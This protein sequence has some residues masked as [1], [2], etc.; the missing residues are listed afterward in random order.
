MLLMMKKNVAVA[1]GRLE[2]EVETTVPAHP[3]H[4]LLPAAVSAEA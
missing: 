1:E 2:V 3:R 4:L